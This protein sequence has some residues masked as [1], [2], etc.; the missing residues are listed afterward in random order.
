MSNAMDDLF[1]AFESDDESDTTPMTTTPA[2]TTTKRSALPPPSPPSTKKPKVNANGEGK[3][4]VD[5]AL[6][7]EKKIATG[8]A[9]DKVSGTSSAKEC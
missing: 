9:E 6:L 2:S 5:T 4:N 8:T 1:D 3:P 7:D